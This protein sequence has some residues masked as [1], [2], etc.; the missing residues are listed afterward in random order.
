V[1]WVRSINFDEDR[2]R[3]RAR[4][5]PRVMAS[6]R[7]LAIT[8]LRLTGGTKHAAVLRYRPHNP[9]RPG[10]WGQGDYCAGADIRWA[11]GSFGE[12]IRT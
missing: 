6:L 11:T 9:G 4:N 1:I 10:L 7:D 2:C 8:I 12:T 3:I 5:G